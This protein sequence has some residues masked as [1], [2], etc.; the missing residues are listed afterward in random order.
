MTGK[1]YKKETVMLTKVEPSGAVN[2]ILKAG[3]VINSI[4][5]DGVKHEV[6]RTYH[7]IDSMLYARVGSS[8]VIN[9][10]RDGAA[11]DITIPIVEKMLTAY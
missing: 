2:G 11:T 7:I 8:V 9:V 10:T 1:I 3:D 6:S 4:T 5:I